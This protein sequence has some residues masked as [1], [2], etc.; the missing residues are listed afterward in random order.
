MIRNQDNYIDDIHYIDEGGRHREITYVYFR[1]RKVWEL[2][3]GFLL[4]KNEYYLQSKD[5][6]V[7][8]CKDQ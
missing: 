7:L 3:A 4:T 6:Y 5:I 2:I 8:K 1:G